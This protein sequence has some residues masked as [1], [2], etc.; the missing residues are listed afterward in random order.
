MA[1]REQ[2]MDAVC[3]EG[4]G[5]AALQEIARNYAL[6]MLPAEMIPAELPVAQNV[7]TGLGDVRSVIAA[8]YDWYA[9][10]PVTSKQLRA[11]DLACRKT[12][13]ACLAVLWGLGRVGTFDATPAGRA[14]V[15]DV[16]ELRAVTAKR[17]KT[18]AAPLASLAAVGLAF[19]TSDENGVPCDVSRAV[20]TTVWYAASPDRAEGFFDAL[21]QFSGLLDATGDE[22]LVAFARADFRVLA[23]GFPVGPGGYTE[24]EAVRTMDPK[25]AAL[26]RE[27]TTYTSVHYP[28]HKLVFR[29][30]ELRNRRWVADYTTRG[31]GYGVWRVTVEE[32]GLSVQ[33]VMKPKARAHVLEHLDE[34]PYHIQEIFLTSIRCRNCSSCG[35]H[36]MFPH[37]DHEHK[38]C[39]V[40]WFY[41][42]PLTVED[43]PSIERLLDV[44][45]A[46]QR[47]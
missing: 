2:Q 17:T 5:R 20:S 7:R 41:T 29:V 16:A 40:T 32:G 24:A 34:L 31:K 39:R 12:V 23:P 35:E 37:G 47:S 18:L 15:V 13:N 45:M 27:F 33:M 21:R 44:H 4:Q 19:E 9:T 38:L 43:L 28:K 26:W 25:T 1:N 3:D 14:F 46:H 8:L 10:Q 36:Q 42:P 11:D 30:P 6:C 22:G